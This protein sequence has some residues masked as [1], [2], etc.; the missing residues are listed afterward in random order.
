MQRLYTRNLCLSFFLFF[1][2]ILV[3]TFPGNSEVCCGLKCCTKVLINNIT[4]W[5]D[6]LG[7]QA[8]ILCHSYAFVFKI[9]FLVIFAGTAMKVE[10]DTLAKSWLLR[11]LVVTLAFCSG[12]GI[13]PCTGQLLLSQNNCVYGN[14][15][16]YI[17]NLML[18]HHFFFFPFCRSALQSTG[19]KG[20]KPTVRAYE[21]IVYIHTYAA[22]T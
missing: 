19:W 6:Y 12:R 18:L 1:F 14:K 10:W 22:L 4:K 16:N 7:V 20:G 11:C 13:C 17:W 9:Q 15:I 8:N 21:E 5:H 2:N 3:K